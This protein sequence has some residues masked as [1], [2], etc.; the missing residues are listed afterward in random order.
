VIAFLSALL[1]RTLHASLRV[2]HVRVEKID[3]L[4]QYILAFWHSLLLLMVHA[5]YR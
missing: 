4:P 2:R 5:R 3:A 1:I